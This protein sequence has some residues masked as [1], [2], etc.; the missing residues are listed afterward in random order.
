MRDSRKNGKRRD[1]CKAT[2]RWQSFT[3]YD[4]YEKDH[5]RP[6]FFVKDGNGWHRNPEWDCWDHEKDRWVREHFGL[7]YET[8]GMGPIP[9]DF[10]REQNRL[11]R[12]REKAALRKAE[13]SGDFDGLIIPKP[14]R[15]IRWLY[16]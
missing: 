8:C 1:L 5:P 11:Q 4:L 2:R 7:T 16:W 9:S 6:P 12:C 3:A 14:R 13:Q 15:S 10:R